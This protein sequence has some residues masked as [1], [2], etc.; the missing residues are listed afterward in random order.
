[1]AIDRGSGNDICHR[2]VA[3]HASTVSCEAPL[4]RDMDNKSD[5]LWSKRTRSMVGSFGK[6]NRRGF[7]LLYTCRAQVGGE[8]SAIPAKKE[9]FLNVC[10]LQATLDTG[11]RM[12]WSCSFKALILRIGS[13]WCLVD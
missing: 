4:K 3:P 8:D 2:S 7:S 6:I 10:L 13:V 5:L 12:W 11:M 1:M 9:I